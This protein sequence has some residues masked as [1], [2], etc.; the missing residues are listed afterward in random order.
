MPRRVLGLLLPV[1]VATIV[2]AAQP[3]AP[4]LT[5]ALVAALRPALPF[6]EARP[7]G[8]PPGGATEPVW[9]GR[10]PRDGEPRVD[11]VANPLNPGN[12]ARALKA[13]EEI[14][15]AAMASQRRSQADY[16]KAVSDFQRTGKVG[17]IREIS[18]ADEG[19][20]GERYDAESQLTVRAQIFE[21][22]YAVEVS[23][24]RMPSSSP[25][26]AGPAFILRVAANT[27][28]DAGTNDEPATV[29][30]CPEQA[31]VFF[32]A[33]RPAEIV[34]ES[35]SAVRVSVAS[36]APGGRGLVVTL[37]GNAE[38]VDRVLQQADWALLR[39]RLG[40]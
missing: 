8:T 31:W 4:S 6:P 14:Q 30:F 1:T 40:G 33:L 7:D 5:D 18:L 25:P 32:G 20:A 10:F 15:K 35:D 24:S 39:A 13:E 16:E 3:D 17:D 28:L 36:A 38:L 19:L 12:R 9:T 26:G 23:T 22:T 11:V 37:S 21:E 2:G 29:R 27:Y 34:S